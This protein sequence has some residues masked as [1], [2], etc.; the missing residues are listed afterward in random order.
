LYM[1]HLSSCHSGK[2]GIFTRCCVW[3]KLYVVY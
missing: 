1:A 2:D 3:V